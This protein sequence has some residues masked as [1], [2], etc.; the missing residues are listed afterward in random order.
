MSYLRQFV[1]LSRDDIDLAGGKGANLGEL[2]RAGLPVRDGFVLT[3]DAYRDF[4]CGGNR[5][6]GPGA[7]DKRRGG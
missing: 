4:V 5:R 7:C 1:E 2:I 6:V 3:T